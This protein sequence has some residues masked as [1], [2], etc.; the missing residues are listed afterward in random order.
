MLRRCSFHS[1][2]CLWLFCFGL[3]VVLVFDCFLFKHASLFFICVASP[4]QNPQLVFF[5]FLFSHSCCSLLVLKKLFF[6]PF[7]M[8]VLNTGFLQLEMLLVVYYF[9]Y[10]HLHFVFFRFRLLSVVCFVC[11]QRGLCNHVISIRTLLSKTGVVNSP[12]VWGCCNHGFR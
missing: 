7:L 8:L 2:I 5:L 6:S 11:V 1:L 10:I 12:F 9:M 3:F 4:L